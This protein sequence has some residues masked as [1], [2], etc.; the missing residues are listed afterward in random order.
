MTSAQIQGIAAVVQTVAALILMGLTAW[1]VVLTRRLATAAG[2]QLARL[3]R[4]EVVGQIE[5]R[6][7]ML[8]E[9]VVTSLGPAPARN[10]HL[11]MTLGTTS[12]EWRY[13]L[14][15]AGTS[16]R[17]ALPGG[18]RTA[19]MLENEATPLEVELRY[20]HRGGD[21]PEVHKQQIDCAALMR[22]WG[23]AGWLQIDSD[24]AR[25]RKTLKEGLAAVAKAVAEAKR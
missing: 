18:K 22:T 13:P 16:E 11:R 15:R 25:L 7:P 19:H 2:D 10:V 20:H 3:D 17:F 4:A 5:P 23:A 21:A 1:Y 8:V 12:T 9:Y 6:G 14:L 24:Q